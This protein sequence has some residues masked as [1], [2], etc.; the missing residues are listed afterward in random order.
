M[1]VGSLEE[2]R[3]LLFL[4]KKMVLIKLYGIYEEFNN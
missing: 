4:I 3:G 1:L 2:G